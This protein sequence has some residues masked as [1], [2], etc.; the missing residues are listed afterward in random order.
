MITENDLHKSPALIQALTG[1]P[2]A[3]FWEL[4]DRLEA[5]YPAYE[6]HRHARSGRQRAMGAGHPYTHSLVMRTLIVLM[7][8]RLHIPQVVVANLL[9]G[10]PSEVSRELR[11]LR[12]LLEQ[13]LP[14]PAV[15]EILAEAQPVAAEEGLDSGQLNKN[16]ALVDAT[17][18]QVYRPPQDNE[19]RKQC[20]SGKKK[21]VH[22]KDRNSEYD[23]T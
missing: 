17:A 20:Y 1:L 16:H 14:V 11:R 4:I 23:R 13:M 9:G 3:V 7:Y 21:S 8:R 15:W 10:S 18:Q 22:V 5:A 6:R 12:P 19:T 2:E